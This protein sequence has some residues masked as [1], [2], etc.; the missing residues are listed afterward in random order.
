MKNLGVRPLSFPLKREKELFDDA[1]FV[2]CTYDVA[3]DG[4][5]EVERTLR[6]DPQVLRYMHFRDTSKLA[7]FRRG[8]A[9]KKTKP[10][11]A[12]MVAKGRLFNPET[13]RV[14]PL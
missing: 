11:T 7:E 4:L 8:P 14:E 10:V 13:M 2:E 9:K 12:S 6:S 3:P 5:K 1:R